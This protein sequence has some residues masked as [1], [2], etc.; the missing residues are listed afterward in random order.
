MNGTRVVEHVMNATSLEISRG[1]ARRT[2]MPT[3]R[4]FGTYLKEA[5]YESVRMLRAPAFGIPFLSLPV[6]LYLLFAVLLFGDALRSDPKGA[7]FV[8]T[9]FD[10][11]GVMG[12]GLFGFGV[13][14]AMEREQGLLTLKRA[15]PMPPA[16]YLLAKMIMAM[17]FG[18]IVTAT[19]IAAALTLGHLPLTAG[20]CFR[21]AAINILGA[22]PFCA[23]GLFIGTRTTG[24]VAPAIT[25]V[26]Y[27]AMIYLSG[28]MFPLPKTMQATAVIWPAY[29]LDQLMFRAL[30]ASSQG[31][32]MVHVAVLAGV[33]LLLTALSVRRLARVG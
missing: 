6:A 28:I 5:R 7:L 4:L 8:F 26:I 14:V 27:M 19:M 9:G 33:T 2:A 1:T 18:V 13:V 25:N 30:G 16:A 10:V 31:A 23:M 32:A 29:H 3:S 11:M 17:V 24:K 15:L 22:L 20:Q 21:V 12:P